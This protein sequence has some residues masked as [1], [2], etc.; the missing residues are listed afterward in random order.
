MTQQLFIW[1]AVVFIMVTVFALKG[2]KKLNAL[3][4]INQWVH[5]YVRLGAEDEMFYCP[6][7]KDSELGQDKEVYYRTCDIIDEI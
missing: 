6:G 7:D 5:R 3:Y 1:F 2:L 4:H